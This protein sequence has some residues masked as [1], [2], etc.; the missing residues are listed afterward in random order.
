VRNECNV[1]FQLKSMKTIQEYESLHPT[2]DV[3]IHCRQQTKNSKSDLL[4]LW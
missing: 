1:S 3:R 2:V 4:S